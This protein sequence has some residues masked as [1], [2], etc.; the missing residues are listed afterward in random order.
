VATTGSDALGSSLFF[1]AITTHPFRRLGKLLLKKRRFVTL[2]TSQN[3]ISD[4]GHIA[5]PQIVAT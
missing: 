3:P 2:V 4:A 1:N 5:K